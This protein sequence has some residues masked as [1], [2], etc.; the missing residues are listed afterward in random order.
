MN[1]Q[2]MKAASARFGGEAKFGGNKKRGRT[3]ASKKELAA[4]KAH[5]DITAAR[6]IAELYDMPCDVSEFN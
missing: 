1:N 2:A 6:E 4:R 5:E 3:A